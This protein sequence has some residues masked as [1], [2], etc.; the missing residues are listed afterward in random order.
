MASFRL[1][2]K[3]HSF[4][5]NPGGWQLFPTITLHKSRLRLRGM[6]FA[7]SATCQVRELNRR[8]SWSQIF[9]MFKDNNLFIS[10]LTM[11]S[12]WWSTYI[13]VGLEHNIAFITEG[14]WQSFS[15]HTLTAHNWQK[16]K[17]TFLACPCHR[18]KRVQAVGLKNSNYTLRNTIFVNMWNLGQFLENLIFYE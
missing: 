15:E 8:R 4:G 12:W 10:P 11:W 2:L 7:A 5:D 6:T 9:R 18:I 14:L 16:W 17:S 13:L 3:K 1:D